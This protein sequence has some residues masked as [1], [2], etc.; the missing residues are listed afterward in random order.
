MKESKF[1]S[2]WVDIVANKYIIY[3]S[4][5]LGD[6]F[7]DKEESDTEDEEG[8]GAN[9]KSSAETHLIEVEVVSNQKSVNVLW[10][11]QSTEQQTNFFIFFMKKK[12][13]SYVKGE[14]GTTNLYWLL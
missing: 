10:Y 6:K 4:L 12:R 14:K 7:L 1:K 5:S 11:L 2:I 8:D 3:T 13:S 9:I